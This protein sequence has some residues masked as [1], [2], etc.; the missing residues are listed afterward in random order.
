VIR[1]CSSS[2]DEAVLV[3]ILAVGSL[4]PYRV[5]IGLHIKDADG[6]FAV[7]GL[8]VAGVVVIFVIVGV[9]IVMF[10]FGSTSDGC[11]GEDG[12]EFF[13]E[14]GGLVA[15]VCGGFEDDD[16][17][18]CGAGGEGGSMTALWKR[19]LGVES[20]QQMCLHFWPRILCAKLACISIIFDPGD[21]R[22]PCK[23]SWASC[24]W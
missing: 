1:S 12:R 9:F 10:V 3:K 11:V 5:L 6:T 14:E 7:N 20:I 21:V 16:Q 8:A 17:S 23:C 13:G 15:K 22:H 4:A 18:V 2:T 24:Q 19:V